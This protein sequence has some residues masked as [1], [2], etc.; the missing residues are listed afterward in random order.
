MWSPFDFIHAPIDFPPEP[1]H[2]PLFQEI[3]QSANKNYSGYDTSFAV[4]SSQSFLVVGF[5][6]TVSAALKP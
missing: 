5:P 2:L 1:L 4:F 6:H 3:H